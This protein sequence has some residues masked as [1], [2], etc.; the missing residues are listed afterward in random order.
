MLLLNANSCFLS[1]RYLLSFYL[2]NG[3]K[4]DNQKQL[5]FS[6]SCFSLFLH[7]RS[8]SFAWNPHKLMSAPMQCSL[9]FIKEKVSAFC[10]P[11]CYRSIFTKL[12]W[13]GDGNEFSDRKEVFFADQNLTFS[14]VFLTDC[15][16][17]AA[18]GSQAPWCSPQQSFN[19]AS[20]ILCNRLRSAIKQKVS[21]D[22]SSN[23]F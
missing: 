2:V 13:T 3:G 18:C 10:E 7:R 12:K 6:L 21:V 4:G 15:S 11:L 19:K 1:K 17:R 9:L 5:I 16:V 23:F 22:L 20:N 8:D 14:Q